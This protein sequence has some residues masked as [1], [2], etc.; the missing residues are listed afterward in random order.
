MKMID[1]ENLREGMICFQTI[2]DSRGIVLI[3]RGA[4]FTTAYI[5]G[6][7]KFDVNR[8]AIMEEQDIAVIPEPPTDAPIIQKSLD[9]CRELTREM[10]GFQ[11]VKIEKKTS[12]I[13]QVIYS[14][15]EK[16]YVQ[17]CLEEEAHDEHLFLHTLR[18]AILTLV[19]GMCNRYNFLN[20]EYLALG[21]LMHDAGMGRHYREEDTDHPFQGFER[22]RQDP[23]LDML[24][25]MVCLQHHEHYDGSGFPFQF[26]RNQITEFSRLIAVANYYDQLLMK[27]ISPRP[28][29]FKVLAAANTRLDP[30]MV[31][32]FQTTML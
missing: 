8:V 6:L 5:D 3:D 18:T 28:A 24:V 25:A 17:R 13:D 30:V 7:R 1:I 11:T 9:T 12:Q 2:C 15:L 26:Q 20:L 27:N 29:V 10:N 22:L 23:E 21:A 32:L 14:V 4:V 31:K 19:M 16:P